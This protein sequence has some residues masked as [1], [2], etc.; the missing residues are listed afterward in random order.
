MIAT[1]PTYMNIYLV[2][3]VQ[4]WQVCHDWSCACEEARAA[5]KQLSAGAF[6]GWSA[7]GPAFV[8]GRTSARVT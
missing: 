3:V 8:A 6:G 4:Y 7:A 5:V 1:V 2:L